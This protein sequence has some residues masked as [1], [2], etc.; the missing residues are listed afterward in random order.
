MSELSADH[1]S[2]AT[3]EDLAAILHAIGECG[4]PGVSRVFPVRHKGETFAA[5]VSPDVVA[6]AQLYWDEL[7]RG[8]TRPVAGPL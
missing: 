5:I 4:E 7:A 8:M 6:A 3:I 1:L 2:R